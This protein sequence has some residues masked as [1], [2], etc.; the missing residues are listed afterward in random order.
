LECGDLP[1]LW[2]SSGKDGG[3]AS[4]LPDLE[5]GEY[6]SGDKSPHSKACD[7]ITGRATQTLE[8]VKQASEASL[9]TIALDHLTLA[10]AA[11]YQAVLSSSKLQIP[12][13]DS[14]HLTAAVN[15]LRQ[16]GDAWMLPR[17]LLTRAWHRRLTDNASGGASDLDEAWEIAERG[18][19]PLF[20]ADVLLTRV[21]L[22][23]GEGSGVGCPVSGKSDPESEARAQESGYPWDSPQEDLAEARG[24]IEKHGYHRRDEELEDAE[25]A[26]LRKEDE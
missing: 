6:Q 16:S 17:G 7:A 3:R 9:L 26:I 4:V 20:Q 10:R 19:M 1:P 24:L 14:D 5:S 8:W 2:I 12:N 25:K 13:F 23:G 11:L 15:G 21:R 18:P 22:F